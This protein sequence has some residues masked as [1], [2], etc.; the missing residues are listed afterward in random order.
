MQLLT[1]II[2]NEWAKLHIYLDIVHRNCARS[3]ECQSLPSVTG[4]RGE[5]RQAWQPS[6][7]Q[8]PAGARKAA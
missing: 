2:D 5:E 4:G 3:W 6:G 7:E 1:F 8:V